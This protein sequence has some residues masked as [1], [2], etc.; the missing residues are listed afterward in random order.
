MTL[1]QLSKAFTKAFGSDRKRIGGMTAKW[2]FIDETKFASLA[3]DKKLQDLFLFTVKAAQEYIRHH[4]I[5]EWYDADWKTVNL[6]GKATDEE[7]ASASER[8]LN[9]YIL[10][11]SLPPTKSGQCGSTR[12]GYRWGTWLGE[13]IYVLKHKLV[14]LCPEQADEMEDAV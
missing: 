12:T 9:G 4:T 11:Y 10:D 6:P 7:K 13:A 5:S 1:K 2:S 3:P 14:D 8:M